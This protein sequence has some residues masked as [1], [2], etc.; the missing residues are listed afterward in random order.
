M[1]VT[2]HLLTGMILQV[3][4]L[5]YRL[6]FDY[7]MRLPKKNASM[8]GIHKVWGILY[9]WTGLA[10]NFEYLAMKGVS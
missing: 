4:C 6:F 7:T 3:G 8:F 2:K 9:S 5:E 10:G 1:G